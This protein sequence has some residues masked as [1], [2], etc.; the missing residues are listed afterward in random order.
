[1]VKRDQQCEQ[2]GHNAQR[3]VALHAPS[4][5]NTAT[6]DIGGQNVDGS[7][8]V[9]MMQRFAVSSGRRFSRDLLRHQVWSRDLPAQAGEEVHWAA[10]QEF[11][12]RNTNVL[13]FDEMRR[14][15]NAMCRKGADYV[16]FTLGHVST[17]LEQSWSLMCS[18]G[19]YDF[20]TFVSHMRF[21]LWDAVDVEQEFTAARV[22]PQ[23]T[24]R[25]ADNLDTLYMVGIQ[26]QESCLMPILVVVWTMLEDGHHVER[27]PLEVPR[28]LQCE[29]LLPMVGVD[30]VRS[31][32]A[33][34]CEISHDSQPCRRQS[35]FV[36]EGMKFAIDITP[37]AMPEQGDGEVCDSEVE[38]VS[39]VQQGAPCSHSRQNILALS[40]TA[41]TRLQHQWCYRVWWH[42]REHLSSIRR[43]FKSLHKRRED[44]MI[45][46]A[47]Y[48]FRQQL[49]GRSMLLKPVLPYGASTADWYIA[50]PSEDV[51]NLY[52]VHMQPEGRTAF[53]TMLVC[54]QWEE[55]NVQTAFA[56][57]LPDNQ[58]ETRE[59]C[60]IIDSFLNT[61]YWYD[62][63]DLPDGTVLRF[64][65]VE[66][67]LPNNHCIVDPETVDDTNEIEAGQTAM[68]PD[69]VSLCDSHGVMAEEDDEDNVVD[70]FSMSSD[71]QVARESD[72]FSGMQHFVRWRIDDGR[73]SN[74]LQNLQYSA[75]QRLAWVTP[76]RLQKL[77]LQQAWHT[78]HFD[79]VKAQL[80]EQG[81]VV[82]PCSL[83]GWIFRH[84]RQARGDSFA[85]GLS[86][87]TPWSLQVSSLMASARLEDSL[88]YTV[89]P[90]I[91]ATNRGAN[92][93]LFLIAPFA[94][95]QH[96]PLMLVV[97]HALHPPMIRMAAACDELCTA[98][99]VFD[100]VGQGA[101]C[102]RRHVCRATF[103]HGVRRR[104][105]A[106]DEVME[107]PTASR[108]SLS[109][110]MIKPTACPS[111]RP[112]VGVHKLG[113]L[114]G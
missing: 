70:P 94:G 79:L 9:N 37:A 100:L 83:L 104:D 76:V 12:S 61:W 107:V 60:W 113:R 34:H 75:S 58:C 88:L 31:H 114:L 46:Q 110:Q 42:D 68:G 82:D 28:L 108:I 48:A 27:I 63:L 33:V 84:H 6:S 4:E 102:N 36:Q 18:W 25:E 66:R 53:A 35:W 80:Q 54:P 13:G 69:L 1:M 65:R 47:S 51:C 95:S 39:L 109:V 87:D 93:Y 30:V 64:F 23:V 19:A 15:F 57:A 86:L 98:R 32:H 89:I 21:Q 59:E 99:K 50:R 111:I 44:C 24:P 41:A 106:D 2:G 52:L 10:F 29:Q 40:L 91:E 97:E 56:K 73:S 3:D 20:P 22:F 26:E 55:S 45:C 92:G 38:D 77:E 71:R 7:D 72:V 62:P 16:I 14:E 90:P 67:A 49:G 78:R 8:I 81:L 5:D 103:V 17:G 101:W 74:S 96:A 43:E 85:W 112:V 105:F 11:V